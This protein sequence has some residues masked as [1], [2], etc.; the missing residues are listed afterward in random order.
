MRGSFI[1]AVSY[2][3]P[4]HR[5][6]NAELASEFPGWN[7]RRAEQITGIKSRYVESPGVSASDMAVRASSKIF[8]QGIERK[9]I[10]FLVTVTQSGDYRLPATA[11]VLHG[12]LGME[13]GA[14]ALDVNL[15]CSG[16]VYGLILAKSLVSSG[17][18]DKVLL[19]TV[20]KSSFLSHPTDVTLRNI[21]GD[22]AAVA[23]ISS[24]PGFAEILESDYG[25]D[26]SGWNHIIVPAGGSANPCCD[27]T[28][29]PSRDQDGNLKYPEYERMDGMEVF[30][31]SVAKGPLTIQAALKKNNLSVDQIDHFL[32]HQANKLIIDTIAGTL[33]IPSA[34]VPINISEVGN[35]SSC[36]IPILLSDLIA[37]G[38]IRANDK[39]V[40]C[41][42][43]VGFSWASTVIAIRE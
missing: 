17:T 31:F 25:T 15:G 35:T 16:F 37:G 30:N 14:G 26:G 36:S 23:V 33:K 43:G 32:L 7:P 11:C 3:L 12:K 21:L 40:L 22:A 29:K 28:K 41:G 18:A 19:V 27:E 10:D 6:A 34:K 24:A 1:E 9:D 20:E 4:E 5:V 39:L 42:F 8:E 2:Y 13:P 38:K